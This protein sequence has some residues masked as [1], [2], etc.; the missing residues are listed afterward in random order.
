MIIVNYTADENFGCFLIFK[1]DLVC[2]MMFP[3]TEWVGLLFMLHFNW[4]IQYVIS[5][6]LQLGRLWSC[7]SSYVKENSKKLLL[8]NLV[9]H[10]GLFGVCKTLAIFFDGSSEEKKFS[11]KRLNIPA[12]P[13]P[14]FFNNWNQLVDHACWNIGGANTVVGA[15]WN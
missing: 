15:N 1:G 3:H 11:R 4:C 8:C 6:Y 12:D 2:F 14:S 13:R 5:T 7:R 10:H 9:N